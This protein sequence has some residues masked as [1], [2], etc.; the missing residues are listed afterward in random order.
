MLFAAC[1]VHV[2]CLSTVFFYK[3]MML[4]SLDN[5]YDLTVRFGVY[6]L[7]P[8]LMTGSVIFAVF[9]ALSMEGGHRDRMSEKKC[10]DTAYSL[11]ENIMFEFHVIQFNAS[12]PI[13][14]VGY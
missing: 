14:D 5:A 4:E 12:I 7:L 10:R 6:F 3:H 1:G 2:P 8:A 9:Y 11:I 13:K